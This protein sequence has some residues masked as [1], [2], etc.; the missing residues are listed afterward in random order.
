MGCWA[1]K[2]LAA[3]NQFLF[4]T[5]LMKSLLI[6]LSLLLH[7]SASASSTPTVQV[8]VRVVPTTGAFTCRYVFTLPPTDTTSVIQ[9]NL[10]KQFRVERVQSGQGVA[11]VKKVYYPYFSDT[12]QQVVVHYP[13]AGRR[14][15]QVT[16]TYSGTLNKAR[17]TAQGLEFSAHS[18]WLP[19]RPLLEY[20]LVDYALAVQVP[21]S[22]QVRSTSPATRARP[23]NYRFAGRTSAIELTAIIAPELQQVQTRGG[24]SGPAISV[25]KVGL[26]LGPAEA[27]ILPKAKEVIAFYNRTMGRQD[28]I[29]RFTVF[30]TGTKQNA[31]GLLDNATIITYPDFD[32]TE[33]EALLILAHEISHKWW[34][35]GSVHTADEWLNEAFAKYSSLL[36]LQASGDTARYQ[37]EMT[38]L[39]QATAN[40]PAII[41]FDPTKAD[42]ATYRRVIYDKGTGILAALK[43]R[44]GADRFYAILAKTAAEKVSTTAQ[45]LA[46]V[47]QVS[48]ADTRAWLTKELSR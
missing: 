46:V 44:V 6:L 15:K 39:I 42:H 34:G 20:E 4:L 23:G 38:K 28:S 45:F 29:T 9:L 41:G 48:S 31:F 25:V 8:Q 24:R 11:Q 26:A 47:E 10:S 7:W 19:F 32:V 27:T 22:Y 1:A 5:R 2:Y 21:P 14:R 35:Y 36:Y 12:L 16:F 43:T 30:L 37:T 3:T 13:P 40:A 18:G 33:P 17:R